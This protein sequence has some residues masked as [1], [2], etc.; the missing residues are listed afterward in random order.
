[1][2]ETIT[3]AGRVLIV[4]SLS[5][6]QY[7]DDPVVDPQVPTSETNGTGPYNAA[8]VDALVAQYAPAFFDWTNHVPLVD[9]YTYFKDNPG[10]LTADGIHVGPAGQISWN[11]LWAWGA[12]MVV[13][14][15]YVPPSA[16]TAPVAAQPVNGSTV[17]VQ[18]QLLAGAFAGGADATHT[19]SR[20]Q[21]SAQAAFSALRWDSGDT[22]FGTTAMT[23]T[24]VLPAN[25][26]NWWR[27]RYRDQRG[28]W[29]AWS[30]PA[31]FISVPETGCGALALLGCAVAAQK[32]VL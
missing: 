17:G 12:G 5:Y 4:P 24:A 23:V 9:P 11:R 1:M 2:Y 6:R 13:Y 27:V 18:P 16:V 8:I 31:W 28:T 29:S 22:P 30:A 32:R 21:I 19:T 25:A 26:T 20:W 10:E 14:S 7:A 3:N 15:N